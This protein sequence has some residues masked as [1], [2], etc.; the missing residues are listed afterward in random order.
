MDTGHV[1]NQRQ[2][3]VIVLI[4]KE[5][6]IGRL[7]FRNSDL[8]EHILDVGGYGVWMSSKADQDPSQR[9]IPVWSLVQFIV[10]AHSVSG[11]FGVK[12]NARFLFLSY[13]EQRNLLGSSMLRS[14]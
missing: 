3:R 7:L 12:D 11:C 14:P 13:V 5:S 1:F 4:P 2:V 6:Q 9:I 10:E 8:M